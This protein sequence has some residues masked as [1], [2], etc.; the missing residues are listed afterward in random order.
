MSRTENLMPP[1]PGESDDERRLREALNRLAG[2]M[3]GTIDA[4]IQFR[5]APQPAQRARHMARGEL[6]KACLLGMQAL[7]LVPVQAEEEA[8]A[9]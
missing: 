4:A 8:G 6:V 1:R 9:K 3:V 2:Q 5:T 7:Y